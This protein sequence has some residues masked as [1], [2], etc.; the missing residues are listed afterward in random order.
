MDLISR[1]GPCL[2]PI[3]DPSWAQPGAMIQCGLIFEPMFIGS[4][5]GPYWMYLV[6]MLGP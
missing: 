5:S 3:L 6:S 1:F 4:I 2:G